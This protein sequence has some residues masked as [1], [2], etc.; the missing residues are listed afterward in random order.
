MHEYTLI[1]PREVMLLCGFFGELLANLGE[2]DEES[3]EVC[4]CIRKILNRHEKEV[5]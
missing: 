3:E 2:L 5:E 4:K 1:P